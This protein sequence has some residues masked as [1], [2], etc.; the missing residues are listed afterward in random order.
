ME[1]DTADLLRTLS[2][3]I[4]R[5]DS[6]HFDALNG[7]DEATLRVVLSQLREHLVRADSR[8]L[9]ALLSC[10]RTILPALELLL[11]HAER[12]GL[13][14][15]DGFAGCAAVALLHARTQHFNDA[16]SFAARLERFALDLVR[17]CADSRFDSM[18]DSLPAA[19]SLHL[20]L[21]PSLHDE[22]L[23]RVSDVITSRWHRVGVLSLCFELELTAAHCQRLA[24]TV[25]SSI[26][27]I[28]RAD[29]AA[30][31]KFA[32]SFLNRGEKC[33]LSVLI[34]ILDSAASERE[35]SIL[36]IELA[37]QHSLPLGA[38]LSS[39]ISA[40]VGGISVGIALARGV[41]RDRALDA[42]CSVACKNASLF[43]ESLQ[44]IIFDGCESRSQTF[45]SLSLDLCDAQQRTAAELGQTSLRSLF[46]SYS[47]VRGEIVSSL[48]AG[49]A[50][51]ER[52]QLFA[53][54]LA[55]LCR[56]CGDLVREQWPRFV[57]FLS[58]A[59][60][61]PSAS[62]ELLFSAL[63][64]L[65]QNSSSAAS[66]QCLVLFRKWLNSRD[67]RVRAAAIL[68]SSYCLPDSIQL[69]S[70]A[71]VFPI[72]LRT[73]LFSTLRQSASLH[74]SAV[75]TLLL[76][77]VARLFRREQPAMIDVLLC[78]EDQREFGV[79][80]REDVAGLL[81]CV[82][83]LAPWRDSSSDDSALRCMR[84]L[85][86][87][88]VRC[89]I[90][91]SWFA[92]AH[93]RLDL[94][95]V[96]SLPPFNGDWSAL[97]AAERVQRVES[98]PNSQCVQLSLEIFECF[99]EASLNGSLPESASHVNIA[100]S[101]FLA[102]ASVKLSALLRDSNS[103]RLSPQAL[104]VALERSTSVPHLCYLLERVARCSSSSDRLLAALQSVERRVRLSFAD[105]LPRLPQLGFTQPSEAESEFYNT[106]KLIVLAWLAVSRDGEGFGE[107]AGELASELHLE[108]ERGVPS[109]LLRLYVKLL[110]QLAPY[111][112]ATTRNS[113]VFCISTL[114][115]N[116]SIGLSALLRSMLEFILRFSESPLCDAVSA[117]RFALAQDHDSTCCSERARD[118]ALKLAENES[119][120]QA[121]IAA[122]LGAAKQYLR[123]QSNDLG[124]GIVHV[125]RMLQL[126]CNEQLS[127]ACSKRFSRVSCSLLQLSSKLITSK[128]V[129][130]ESFSALMPLPEVLA[131]WQSNPSTA[132]LAEL[133]FRI[134]RLELDL[135]HFL[136]SHTARNT[137]T[138]ATTEASQFLSELEKL[139]SNE[140]EPV[141]REPAKRSKRKLRSRNAFIDAALQNE[142]GAENYADLEDFIVCKR[143]KNYR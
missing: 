91:G 65:L 4:A 45:L 81:E 41:L 38:V 53:S 129:S 58:L 126:L 21:A 86:A 131:R 95:F 134:E 118:G 42:L 7:L 128:R 48:L 102:S 109:S 124:A 47:S 112:S 37:T 60:S 31:C 100:H 114:L 82:L 113:L 97:H 5:G 108:V 122:A 104:A 79:R 67:D 19:L 34:A 103:S 63:Q 25:T 52:A 2:A 140:S 101:D 72:S 20:H 50:G 16:P 29:S 85:L 83:S 28:D 55:H 105:D 107:W 127:A 111:S 94:P 70:R 96:D 54:T 14:E 80:L 40:S 44:Q 84:S 10:E 43:G 98:V 141:T 39:A 23:D 110:H 89:M 115:R 137:I 46:S 76:P 36:M 121:S 26:L 6:V 78:F 9:R 142:G 132:L 136:S 125:V 64:P 135:K 24:D 87:S 106:R 92:S 32:L 120:K 56:D 74:R 90:D 33:W 49:I 61:L 130:R 17:F 18:L 27:S 119:C 1:L 15:R 133:A 71:L 22:L 3:V 59:P 62:L 51:S 99:L 93:I 8:L 73:L 35:N 75:I 143:G 116:H 57:D 69:L 88:Q 66:Q 30:L 138:T 13:N 11:A 68:G 123:S 77:R 12:S 139:S 117:V